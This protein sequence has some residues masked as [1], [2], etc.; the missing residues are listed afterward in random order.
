M[1]QLEKLLLRIERSSHPVFSKPRPTVALCH[2]LAE[3]DCFFA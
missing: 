3:A 1:S 2:K